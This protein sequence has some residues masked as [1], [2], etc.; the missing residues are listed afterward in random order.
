[1]IRI[2][3]T[4][5]PMATSNHTHQSNVL[6]VLEQNPSVQIWERQ[7]SPASHDAPLQY[8]FVVFEQDL[9][10]LSM[11]VFEAQSESRVHPVSSQA[12]PLVSHEIQVLFTQV[13]YK[14]S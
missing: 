8:A 13:Y 11:Q 4:S 3:T 1:M 5:P 12:R 6:L 14:Q 9:Q 7:L 2:S 10:M